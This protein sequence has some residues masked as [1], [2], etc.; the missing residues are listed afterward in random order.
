MLA[1]NCRFQVDVLPD[2]VPSH[3]CQL[4]VLRQHTSALSACEKRTARVSR[5]APGQAAPS[6]QAEVACGTSRELY[7]WPQASRMRCTSPPTEKFRMS[8]RDLHHT[9]CQLDCQAVHARAEFHL[10]LSRLMKPWSVMML[11]M[12]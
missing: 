5:A 6:M 2:Q 9:Y 3:G 1:G 12:T 8:R 4:G 7:Q 11:S 10:M